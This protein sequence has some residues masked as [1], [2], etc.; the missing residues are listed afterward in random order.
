MRIHMGQNLP[1]NP[2]K[3]SNELIIQYKSQMT[4]KGFPK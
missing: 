2:T 4:D 3:V 1:K